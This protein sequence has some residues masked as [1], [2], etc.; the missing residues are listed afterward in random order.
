MFV[1]RLYSSQLVL[2]KFQRLYGSLGTGSNFFEAIVSDDR[3]WDLGNFSKAHLS[4]CKLSKPALAN[5]WLE[6]VPVF[7]QPEKKLGESLGLYE[8]VRFSLAAQSTK[9][10]PSG[11]EEL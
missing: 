10:S 7:Q 6:L 1:I 11:P 3:C 9:H 8:R 2:R 5:A 4:S